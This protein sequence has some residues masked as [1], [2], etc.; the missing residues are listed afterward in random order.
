[1][2]TFLD[3]KYPNTTS[4]K[5]FQAEKHPLNNYPTTVRGHSTVDT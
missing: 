3:Q 1:M 2:E 5:I 4:R